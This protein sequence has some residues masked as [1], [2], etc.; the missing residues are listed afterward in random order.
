MLE[1]SLPVLARALDGKRGTDVV[2]G[3]FKRAVEASAASTSSL[4]Y[5]PRMAP[6]DVMRA[7]NVGLELKWCMSG[8]ALCNC[9]WDVAKLACPLADVCPHRW[10]NERCRPRPWDPDGHGGLAP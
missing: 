8:D 5:W 1:D 3:D 6:I 7:D 4:G 10:R 9:A 2:E